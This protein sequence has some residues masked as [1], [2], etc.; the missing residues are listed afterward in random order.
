[1]DNVVVLSTSLGSVKPATVFLSWVASS[2]NFEIDSAVAAVALL[3]C[4]LITF[5]LFVRRVTSAA[6]PACCIAELEMFCTRFAIWLD[7]CSISSSA[8]PAFSASRAPPTTS[9]V[10]RYMDTTASFMSD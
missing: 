3:V 9:V 5:S 4:M 10:L 2:E 6:D 7:T 1:M 8:A